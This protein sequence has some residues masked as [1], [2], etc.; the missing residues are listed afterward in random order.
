MLNDDMS[1]TRLIIVRIS[2]IVQAHDFPL[3]KPHAVKNE[4]KPNAIMTLPMMPNNPASS[5]PNIIMSVPTSIPNP[6]KRVPNT[7]PK[8]IAVIPE[9][10]WSIARIVIPVGLVFMDTEPV[11]NMRLIR[12]AIKFKD[13]FTRR[14]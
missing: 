12:Y 13:G 7:T 3:S 4:I 9:M 8:A 5:L 2:V 6:P 1:M 10:I 11:K 14:E